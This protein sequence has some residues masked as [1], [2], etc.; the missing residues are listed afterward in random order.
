MGPPG[1]LKVSTVKITC[2]KSTAQISMSKFTTDCFFWMTGPAAEK[3]FCV[4][5]NSSFHSFFN[6][7]MSCFNTCSAQ[8]STTNSFS[9]LRWAVSLT[10]GNTV[11]LHACLPRASETHFLWSRLLFRSHWLE[12]IKTVFH[13]TW[14][15]WRAGTRFFS[16]SVNLPPSFHLSILTVFL[17]W[18]CLSALYCLCL[19]PFYGFFNVS[20]SL[21]LVSFTIRL[22]PISFPSPL[23]LPAPPPSLFCA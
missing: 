20:L 6:T 23:S 10:Y 16:C 17:C 8:S 21:R 15:K 3:L 5:Y 18:L 1:P 4:L 19:S 2:A 14:Q 12:N 13:K 9:L 7:K 22:E 11:T